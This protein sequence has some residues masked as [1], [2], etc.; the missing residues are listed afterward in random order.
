[1]QRTEPRTF[2]A[3]S[4]IVRMDQPYSRIADAL[5]DYQYWAPNDPQRNPYDD[6]GWTFPEAFNV[7]AVRVM[8]AKVLDAQ[9]QRVQGEVRA[10][11][12]VTSADAQVKASG[13]VTESTG[14]VIRHNGDNALA[15]LR[16]RMKDVDFQVAEEPFEADGEKFGR[17]SF[18]VR[19]NGAD[20][21][22]H[23][24]ELGIKVYAV[25]TLPTVKT[26]PA[27][28]ARVAILHTWTS[29]QTEGWWRQAFD[30][31]SIPFDYISTQDVAKDA[32][33][34]AKYDVIVFPP[35]GGSI[36]EGMPMWRNPMPWKNT[37]ETPNLGTIAQ[38]DDMRP[39]LGWNG[40][41][42]LQ[43]FVKRGG[44]LIGVNNTADFAVQYGLT[45]GVSVNQARALGS[46]LPA[47]LEDRR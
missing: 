39:G 2:P 36:I 10:S 3:G 4:Y 8:D 46:R 17:G 44:V 47:A 38:T 12:G 9:V 7:Q 41:E 18:I 33:L 5:L 37:P 23:A 24:T 1:V 26:H 25:K 29:T 19:G 16:Y 13:T 42:N 11:G 34:N 27:R 15:T 6:T 31:L 20:L 45:N 14:F 35:S 40:L 21:H 22:K 30:F 43:N 28:A 32:N